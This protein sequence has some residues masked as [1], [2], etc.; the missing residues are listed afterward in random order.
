M[1]TATHGASVIPGLAWP[2]RVPSGTAREGRLCPCL[3]KTASRS[4]PTQYV[5]P[6]HTTGWEKAE[7]VASAGES[8]A[9]GIGWVLTKLWG[10]VLIIIGIGV[11]AGVNNPGE[12]WGVRR[13]VA[14]GWA[15]PLDGTSRV[16]RD[17][18]GAHHRVGVRSAS[19]ST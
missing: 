16:H 4:H 6:Q 7:K 18:Y 9:H 13:S 11:L 17:L 3:P 2:R 8:V 10:V 14:S 12:L 5:Q 15:L 19:W 1:G